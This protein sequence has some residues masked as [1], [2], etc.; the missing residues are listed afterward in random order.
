MFRQVLYYTCYSL[1]GLEIY[2]KNPS[3]IKE[4]K[5]Q[6]QKIFEDLSKQGFVLAI[7]SKNIEEV[8]LEVFKKHPEM[9]LK[10]QSFVYKLINWLPK[11]ENIKLIA[12]ELDIGL[13]NICFIDDNPAEREEVRLTL[14]NVYVPELPAEISDWPEFIK[15]LPELSTIK[16]TD[17]DRKKTE[18]YNI[19]HQ[20]KES[21]L[22]ATS[23]DDFLY[24]LNMKLS[25][26][27]LNKINKQRIIQL[28]AK[29]NQFNTTM[30]QYYLT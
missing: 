17:E 26:E 13:S 12:K 22:T 15:Q 3:N 25:F 11:P 20:I 30:T 29:T 2:L 27:L 24:G 16:L 7:C 19:R 23:R 28:I 21:Q 4:I 1:N 6:I 9:V 18:Q 8:A 5:T 14:P 10:E